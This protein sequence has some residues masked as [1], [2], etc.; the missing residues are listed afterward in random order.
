[1]KGARRTI[2]LLCRCFTVLALTLGT[3]SLVAG[4]VSLDRILAPVAD[5]EQPSRAAEVDRSKTE[6]PP[7]TR[8]APQETVSLSLEAVV[9]RI[10]ELASREVDS[11]GE[12]ELKGRGNW[13]PVLI[14][15][16]D[17]WD[18]RLK[19]SFSPDMR[20]RW[21]ASLEILVNGE[22]RESRHLKL[23][24]SLFEEVWLV[25]QKLA[26]GETPGK[27][28]LRAVT[29]DVFRERGSPVPATEG[30]S[31]Y[32]LRRTLPEGRLL[33]WDD[34]TERPAVR[35]GDIVEIR[36]EK[37]ALQVTVRGR[38]LEDGVIGDTVTVKNTSSHRE[39]LTKVTGPDEVTFI[40]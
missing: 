29:R 25:Q 13:D 16:N 32:E 40:P 26:R 2:Q 21:Y 7:D 6:D 14:K 20:G 38:S 31:R 22:S 24:A 37:G 10:E 33:T 5:A 27:D 17:A 30:L 4:S 35:R 3:G 8:E 36:V 28:S 19:N 9:E 11:R 15:G 39:L 34:L 23:E 12:L 18:I 1:M